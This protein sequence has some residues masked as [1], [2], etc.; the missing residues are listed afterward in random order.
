[1]IALDEI[2]AERAAA[3][4]RQLA[5]AGTRPQALDLPHIYAEGQAQ[6]EARQSIGAALGVSGPGGG[7]HRSQAERAAQKRGK[8]CPFSDPARGAAI[9][10]WS[11]TGPAID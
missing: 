5:L 6:G 3:Q 4:A 8:C 9:L 1:M 7:L 10:S 11:C 2:G